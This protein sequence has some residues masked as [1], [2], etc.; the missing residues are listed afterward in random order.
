MYNVQYVCVYEYIQR[1]NGRFIFL[2]FSFF[3]IPLFF[4]AL[5]RGINSNPNQ[6]QLG[7]MAGP[8]PGVPNGW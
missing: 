1:V 5:Q 7:L 6:Q 8:L 3:V 4:S 2:I